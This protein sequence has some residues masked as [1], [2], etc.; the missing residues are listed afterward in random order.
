MDA[1]EK[2]REF[3]DGLAPDWSPPEA[4]YNIREELVD[5]MGIPEGSL[6]VD[7]GSGRGVMFPHLLKTNPC[8]LISVELS[9][10]M[11]RFAQQDHDDS[12]ISYINCDILEADLPAVDAAVI[13]NAYPHFLDKK[14]LSRKLAA[15]VKPGGMFVIAHS[16]SKEHINNAHIDGP[17]APL[18]MLIRDADEE[19]ADYAEFF[20]VD[21]LVDSNEMY[22]IKLLRKEES[23]D[24]DSDKANS[25]KKK[26]FSWPL[27]P[28]CPVKTY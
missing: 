11:S 24:S 10:E 2:M 16:R 14:A 5:M 15:H 6:I 1:N 9:A 20:T 25:K 27:Y 17:M 7:I 28:I 19:A 23:G 13:F 22:F 3:F 4:D 18:S 26:I 8:G 12:R 21:T